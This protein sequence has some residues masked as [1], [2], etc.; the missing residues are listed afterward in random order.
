VFYD[1]FSYSFLEQ[2]WR[3]WAP[4]GQ[5]P[6]VRRVTKDRRALTTAVG[7][8]LSGKIYKRYFEGGMDSDDVITALEHV[9]RFLPKGFILICDQAPIHTSHALLIYFFD[10]PEIVVEP[11]PKYAPELNPEEYCHGNVKAQ[12]SNATPPD[13]A[14]M[15][16]FLD[17]G[18]ARLRKRPDLLLSFVHA[19]GLPVRQLWQN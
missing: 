15:Q 17:R 14:A 12:A 8:T 11:L 1:E 3:T 4:R 7:L 18:F 10:H 9:R 16:T 19:A 13:R 5:R 6:I 2:L